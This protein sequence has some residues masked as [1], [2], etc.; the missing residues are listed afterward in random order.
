MHTR[1][2]MKMKP[3]YQHKKLNKIQL[4]QVKNVFRK[5]YGC[6]IMDKIINKDIG[7]EIDIEPIHNKTAEYQPNGT[8]HLTGLGECRYTKA[9]LNYSPKRRKE[10]E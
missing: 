9:M 6:T 7:L 10:S 8:E 1:Y 4:V 2:Y 3:R 5:C